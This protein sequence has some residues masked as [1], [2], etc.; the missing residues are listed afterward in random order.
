MD[1]SLYVPLSIYLYPSSD[2]PENKN[3]IVRSKYLIDSNHECLLIFLSNNRCPGGHLK[4]R[5]TVN[6]YHDSAGLMSLK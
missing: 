4:S 1:F 2:L 5:G 3:N 6:V